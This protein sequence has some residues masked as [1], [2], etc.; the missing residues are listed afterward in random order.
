MTKLVL[1]ILVLLV[2]L[3]NILFRQVKGVVE[4]VKNAFKNIKTCGDDLFAPIDNIYISCLEDEEGY[5]ARKNVV[6]YFYNSGG[7]I[8]TE[9]KKKGLYRLQ[10]RLDF[11]EKNKNFLYELKRLCDSTIVALLIAYAYDFTVKPQNML[12]NSIDAT[13][14][15]IS[16]LVGIACVVSIYL[17]YIASYSVKGDEGRYTYLL[18]DYEI[19]KIKDKIRNFNARCLSEFD[20][21][22]LQSQYNIMHTLSKMKKCK[23]EKKIDLENLKKIKLLPDEKDFELKTIILSDLEVILLYKKDSKMRYDDLL[24]EDYQS[25][26]KILEKY[27]EIGN[28]NLNS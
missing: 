2:L 15:L 1:I 24:N 6:D 20:F 3:L 16:T 9:I 26:Y 28:V 10:N 22:I 8:D 25:Y 17:I 14:M 11:L 27:F 21:K 7:I 12:G 4:K 23:K 13:S 5:N 19:E 18:Y